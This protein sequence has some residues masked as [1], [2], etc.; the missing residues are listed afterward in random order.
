MVMLVRRSRYGWEDVP[1]SQP[2]QPGR[3]LLW[4]DDSSTKAAVLGVVDEDTVVVMF[5][6]R[7]EDTF[8]VTVGLQDALTVIGG[9][10][11]MPTVTAVLETVPR[12]IPGL[13]TVPRFLPGL[14]SIS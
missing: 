4:P 7:F 13:E 3:S 12:F 2:E 5:E 10:Q 1:L 9:S 11:V 6:L 14:E 8:P